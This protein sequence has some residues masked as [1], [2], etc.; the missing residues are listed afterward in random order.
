MSPG[1]GSLVVQLEFFTDAKPSP[2]VL[3]VSSAPSCPPKVGEFPNP[4]ALGLLGEAGPGLRRPNTAPKHYT[5]A[6][7][8]AGEE[9][10]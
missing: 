6:A 2:K 4:P 5:V 9:A 10:E 8:L 7:P 1:R 3:T